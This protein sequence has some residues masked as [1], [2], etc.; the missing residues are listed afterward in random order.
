MRTVLF[1]FRRDLRL[2]DNVGLAQ[3]AACGARVVPVYV[4]SS[5][6]RDH[7]WTG[8]KRQAFLCGNLN[9]LARNLESIGSRLT[10]R[11]GDAL[12][13]LQRLAA[14]TQAEGVYFNRDP[15]PFGSGVEARLAQWCAAAGLACQGFKDAV[16]HEAN[17]VLTGEG[18]PYRVYTPYSKNWLGL[19]KDT[20][21]GS[22]KA[23][24]PAAEIASQ[25]LPTLA[26]WGL[27]AQADASLPPAG[28]RAA[29][30]RMQDFISGT[31]LSRYGEQRDVPSVAGTSGLSADLRFGLISIRELHALAAERAAT[32]PAS[33]PAAVKYIKELAWRE[34]YMAILHFYPDVLQADF[35][36]SYKDVAWPGSEAGFA[37][38][39]AGRTGFPIVDAG[40]RQLLKTGWMH[41]RVR[42]I[43]AMFL[44]KDLHCHWKLGEQ[45][46]HQHLIDAEIASNNG[47][48]QWSAGT[49]ADAAPYF[50]IQ[51][52][53]SQTKRFDPSG[54]YIR[55]WVPEL[56]GVAGEKFWQPPADGRPLTADYVLP[57]VDHTAE[58][59][60]TLA[61]FKIAK[62]S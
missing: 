3:A 62:Q 2:T 43:V 50:R 20:P 58:R 36:L 55:Q 19:A 51:N 12:E 13:A 27:E 1:W 56:A 26:H 23:L 8:P 22:V 42:M 17:E 14:E 5:W 53:W 18:G 44:T 7:A 59:D 60:R 41:N 40:M 47:G 32:D 28:E 35:N 24:G 49:G 45:F 54:A 48:W 46:F 61:R 38:W 52:P 6:R 16:L 21:T 15:D 37:A 31:A 25:P 4:L 29:R 30:G 11:E 39:C 10:V 9:S 33:A 34:F 57:M